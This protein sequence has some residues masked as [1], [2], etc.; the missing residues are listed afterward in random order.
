MAIAFVSGS[1]T[2]IDVVQRLLALRQYVQSI[3]VPHPR[4]TVKSD[5]AA[6]LQTTTDLK[7]PSLSDLQDTEKDDLG[8]T[9]IQKSQAP[10]FPKPVETEDSKLAFDNPVSDVGTPDGFNP[11]E[12]PVQEVETPGAQSQPTLR[13]DAVSGMLS[14][15]NFKTLVMSGPQQTC[16]EFARTMLHDIGAAPDKMTAEL[17]TLQISIYKICAVNGLVVIN[18]RGGK[19]VVSPRRAR[20]DDHCVRAN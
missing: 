17:N 16:A 6:Q 20:P 8:L 7:A 13:K 18:C 10:G 19:I 15:G 14:I 11:A 5:I 2:E 3:Q 1:V 9:R 12:A 4:D